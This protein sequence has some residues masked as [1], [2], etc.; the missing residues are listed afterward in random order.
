MPPGFDQIIVDRLTEQRANI[1][2]V[3]DDSRACERLDQMPLYSRD[4]AADFCSDASYDLV[5]L[6]VS[7]EPQVERFACWQIRLWRWLR[8]ASA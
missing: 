3:C 6:S 4:I 7:C 2:S 5:E 1:D 8:A